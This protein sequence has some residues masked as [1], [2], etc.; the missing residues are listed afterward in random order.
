M[1][2]K[3]DKLE[4]DV[5]EVLQSIDDFDW[6]RKRRRGSGP[7]RRAAARG[8]EGITRRAARFTTG[9]HLMII[10]MIL[11][12]I[13]AVLRLQA[14]GMWLALI[15]FVLFIIGLFLSARGKKRAQPH[16]DEPDDRG[17]YWRGRY[18]RYDDG[19]KPDPFR[20]LRRKRRP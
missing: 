9:G 6:Q 10:G 15:G 19:P 7:A 18:V 5:E 8:L 1:S 3:S 14:F 11:L 13:G 2:D 17:G 16:P 20:W 12:L 4:R